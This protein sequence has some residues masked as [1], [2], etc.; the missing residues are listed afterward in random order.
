MVRLSLSL[1]SAATVIA[2]TAATPYYGQHRFSSHYKCLPD[3]QI[4]EYHPFQLFSYHLDTYVSKK[5][6]TNLLVGGINGDKTFQQLQLC[7]VSLDD[8]ECTTAVP[9]SCI[10]QGVSYLIRVLQPSQGY[11]RTSGGRVDIVKHGVDASYFRLSRDDDDWGL[12]IAPV[13]EYEGQDS[14]LT[15]TKA[16]GP[17]SLTRRKKSDVSQFFDLEKPRK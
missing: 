17:I 1:L 3:T 8:E 10:Y 5:I 11:L 13:R 7:A 6:G 16:G 14:V 15:T 12:R 9:T 2:L 4:K